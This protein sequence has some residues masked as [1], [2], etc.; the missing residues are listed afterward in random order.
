MENCFGP[1]LAFSDQFELVSREIRSRHVTDLI[2]ISAGVGY[3]KQIENSILCSP[4][5]AERK[6]GNTALRGNTGKT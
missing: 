4:A 6:S 1:I 3:K 2:L 5:S